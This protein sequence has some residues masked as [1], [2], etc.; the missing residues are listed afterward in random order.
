[1]NSVSPDQPPQ[2]HIER[3]PTD[4]ERQA[5]RLPIRIIRMLSARSQHMLRTEYLQPLQPTTVGRYAT[6]D[7]KKSPLALL[8][9][10]C[11]SIGKDTELPSKQASYRYHP[12]KPPMPTGAPPSLAMPSL[13]LHAPTPG[14]FYS[15]YGLY[16]AR[17]GAPTVGYP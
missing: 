15:P 7:A 6:L 5:K 9:Q 11:S 16:A 10:T 2:I 17:L 12:Y 14:A 13:Q 8:A 1:M 3:P 4:P